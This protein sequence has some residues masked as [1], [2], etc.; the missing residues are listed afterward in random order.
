[1]ISSTIVNRIRDRCDSCKEN[2]KCGVRVDKRSFAYTGYKDKTIKNLPFKRD[3]D[4]IKYS[5]YVLRSRIRRILRDAADFLDEHDIDYTISDGT[6]LGAVRGGDIIPWDDDLDI[7]ILEK[8]LEK[9]KGL[10][11]ELNKLGYEFR[12]FGVTW[13]M[14]PFSNPDNNKYYPALDFFPLKEG[15]PH[16]NNEYDDKRKT[17]VF[18]SE[19]AYNNFKTSFWYHDDLFPL[20]EYRVNNI[21]VKG[22][23]DPEPY[24]DRAYKNWK[25]K[26]CT[27]GWS[28]EDDIFR[29]SI[30]YEVDE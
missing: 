28:H 12:E 24:L 9:L 13:K 22:P 8:D 10:R 23:R 18:A 26:Y 14:Y 4:D 16:P 20:K 27:P 21:M 29:L 6:L 5:S 17:Y 2:C 11:E 19:K 25:T 1:M 3:D 15:K 30:C 7:H